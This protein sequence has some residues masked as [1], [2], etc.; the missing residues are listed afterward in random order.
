M[1]TIE[2]GRTMPSAIGVVGSG[3]WLGV[4]PGGS[5]FRRFGPTPFLAALVGDGALD[6]PS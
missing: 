1:P 6:I 2:N 5:A 4:H 3:A